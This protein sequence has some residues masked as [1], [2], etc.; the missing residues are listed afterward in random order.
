MIEEEIYEFNGRKESMEWRKDSEG[1]IFICPAGSRGFSECV[2]E[3]I[4]DMTYSRGG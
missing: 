4:V 1:N 3:N 2:G